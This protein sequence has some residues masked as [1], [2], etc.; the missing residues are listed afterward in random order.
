MD[1]SMY[2]FQQR[3]KTIKMKLKEWN[4]EHFG[5]IF[6]E[7]ARLEHRLAEIQQKGMD[8]EFTEELLQEEAT[9][10]D[11][12]A[13]RETQE[14]IYWKEKSR[15]RWL[16][17]GERNMKF[18]HRATIQHRTQNRILNLKNDAGTILEDHRDIEGELRNYFQD[19]LS[20]PEVDRNP[21]IDRITQNVPHLITPDI[22]EILMKPVEISEVE[23][24]INH[25]A[26]GTAPG[27]DGF[28]VTFFHKFWDILKDEVL[29]LVE[30]SRI[31]RKVLPAFNSTFITLLPKAEGANHPS[32]FRPI[33]LCNVIYKI[34]TKVIAN[35]LKPI[36]NIL[37]APEQ[38]GFVEGR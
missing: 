31:D 29:H 22:N 16:Q 34:I 25:M 1:R 11:L 20:E 14:E 21:A 3:L 6:Q 24:A 13:Q 26:E 23:D 18:F 36:M 12:I 7:K 33:S 5:N 9:T 37:I 32:K 27:Q 17:E 10:L 4:K 30:S 2:K 15:N 28:T 8:E 19:V 38:S 35:R